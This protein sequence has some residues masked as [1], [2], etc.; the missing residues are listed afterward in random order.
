[1]ATGIYYQIAPISWAEDNSSFTI[2]GEQ[3][4]PSIGIPV[5]KDNDFC[6]SVWRSVDE[7]LGFA[8]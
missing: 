1:M 8:W 4:T 6:N 7:A 3:T 5:D 2:F